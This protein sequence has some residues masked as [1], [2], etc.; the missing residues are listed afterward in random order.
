V[1]IVNKISSGYTSRVT[2]LKI[3]DVSGTRD[4]IIKEMSYHPKSECI[5]SLHFRISNPKKREYLENPGTP[6]DD[7][8]K[9]DLE[10]NLV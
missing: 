1:T 6:R 10:R 2:W 8:I 7:N 5:F 3:K 9:M 4:E